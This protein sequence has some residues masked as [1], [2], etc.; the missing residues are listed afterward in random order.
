MVTK[1]M[2]FSQD[3][4]VFIVESYF[5]TQSLVAVQDLFRRKYR[6]KPA[7]NKTSVL[8]L[9][10]KF[11]QTGSVNNKEHNRSVTVLNTETL[12]EIKHRLRSSPKKID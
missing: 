3:E 10:A 4:R 1:K 8:R 12:A 7:P 9:V 2:V 11:R 6:N 5:S